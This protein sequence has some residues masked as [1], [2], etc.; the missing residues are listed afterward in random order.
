[1]F[2]FK[3]KTAYEMRIGD[4]SSDVCSS[5]LDDAVPADGGAAE[6]DG[7]RYHRRQRPGRAQRR[8][9]RGRDGHQTAQD[10]QES[11]RLHN[12]LREACRGRV[13]KYVYISLVSVSLKKNNIAYV[14]LDIE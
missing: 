4:W 3:Q 11:A 12:I 9:E 7:D 5:D 13:C 14:S 1:M 8:G 6:H 2:Y 10:R